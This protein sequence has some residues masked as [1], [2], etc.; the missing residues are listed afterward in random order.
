[1]PDKPYVV[2][3]PK[4][5]GLHVPQKLDRSTLPKWNAAIK[6]RVQELH[7]SNTGKPFILQWGPPYASSPALHAGHL[8]NG[9]LKDILIKQHL[10]EGRKVEVRFGWDCH[11]LPIENK[12]KDRVGSDDKELLKRECREFA[13]KSYEGQRGDFHLF[14]IYSTAPDY[15][16]MDEDYVQ[17]EK[18]IFNAL[19]EAGLIVKKN[20]PTWY[21]PSLGT[22]LANS[23]IEYGDATDES[24]YF[25]VRLV[26]D[27]TGSS[28]PQPPGTDLLVWTTTEWTI[29]GNQAVCLNSNIDYVYVGPKNFVCSRK[30]A[31]ENGWSF[32]L[33]DFKDPICSGFKTY[34]SP[35]GE[36]CP[37]LWDDFV[38]EDV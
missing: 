19:K 36:E 14:G 28:Y 1:M 21:S 31:L 32:G 16:T 27:S 23:E 25:R 11:G 8:L 22:T 35:S 33:F 13:T 9:T 24:V 10:N 7:S 3:L 12:V 18:D 17:R 20:K 37:I 26:W 6:D 30:L 2:Y 5:E 38:T 34:L 29:A 15:L 4:T